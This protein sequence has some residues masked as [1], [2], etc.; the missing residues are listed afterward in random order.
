MDTFSSSFRDMNLKFSDRTLLCLGVN[1]GRFMGLLACTLPLFS[2]RVTF[3]ID[4]GP[5]TG[6]WSRSLLAVNV[7]CTRVSRL[8]YLFSRSSF[9]R[10]R[11]ER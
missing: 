3:R 7:E 11:P 2:D 8:R 1:S 10:G 5:C 4:I 9:L 6:H